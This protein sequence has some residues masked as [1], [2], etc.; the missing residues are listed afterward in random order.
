MGFFHQVI[1]RR[2]DFGSPPDYFN[3]NWNYYKRGFGAPTKDFWIGNDLIYALT[4]QGSYSV[5]FEMQHANTT[6]AYALYEEFW[7]DDEDDNYKLHISGYSGTAGDSMKEHDGYGFST[8]L[9]KQ[10]SSCAM[11]RSSG[12]WFRQCLT[13]NLNGIYR[14]GSYSASYNDGVEWETFGGYKN[15]MISAEIK[16]RP[17]N[18]FY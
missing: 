10:T 3:K 11:Q 2:G 9:G 15:S 7:I 6:N 4:N 13:C 16:I 17:V 12:W 18:Y 8:P 14:K 5:R 1:Q